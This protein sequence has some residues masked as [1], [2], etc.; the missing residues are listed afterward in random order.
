VVALPTVPPTPTV[1][2]AMTVRRR[3]AANLEQFCM[4][5]IPPIRENAKP[6]YDAIPRPSKKKQRTDD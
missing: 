1:E 6:V 5:S 3:S 4:A 2:I